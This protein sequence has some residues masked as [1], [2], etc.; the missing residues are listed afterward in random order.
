MGEIL[1]SIREY[2]FRTSGALLPSP[3]KVRAELLYNRICRPM[4]PFMVAIAIGLILFILTGIRL[5]RGTVVSHRETK[6]M[7]AGTVESGLE[8]GCTFDVSVVLRR[9]LMWV[10]GALAVYL[11]LVLAL[12][13]FVSG[14]APFAGTYCIMMLT[15]FLSALAATVLSGRVPVIQAPGFLICGFAMLMAS[16]S[17]SRMKWP[18]S[19]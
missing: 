16:L 5:S 9:A 2:Q 19:G 17:S 15:A 4:V 11:A 14:H 8:S 3:P 12:R 7:S 13:W 1:T 6:C 18:H 10:S